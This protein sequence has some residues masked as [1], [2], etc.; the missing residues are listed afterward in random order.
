MSTESYAGT[1]QLIIDPGH[2]GT[3]SGAVGNGITEKKLT[4]DISLYQYKRF[5]ELGIRVALTR[6]SDTTLDPSPRTTK[7]KNSGAKHCLSNHIN[8]ASASTA[9]GAEIIHSIHSNGGWAKLIAE[10]LK[11]A[12]Q[13]LRPTPT[14]SKAQSNGQ[15][16]FYMQRL[17]GSVETV[18]TEYGFLTNKEDA[19]RLQKNW[20]SYAEAA[21]K[22]Y[23]LYV[24]HPYTPP[25][26]KPGETGEPGQP[27]GPGKPEE[28]VEPENPGETI[29]GFEDIAGHW[30]QDSIVKAIR[31]GL[32]NGVSTT[33]FA[34]DQPLTRAQIAV[35][36]DR[37]GLSGN[38]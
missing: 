35:I 17:T 24:S 25:G 29:E 18:I 38:D 11:N 4:L 32:M 3:D 6:N 9:L 15:D 33:R 13:V 12:G 22:A 28:P 23:C 19:A 34:P 31:S 7:V 20:E 2:G 37:A 5:Q 21:V 1:P 8:A 30:A 14:Y 10:Q 27:E 36:L 26:T 16:Y